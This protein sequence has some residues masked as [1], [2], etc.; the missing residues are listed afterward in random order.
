MVD[1]PMVAISN[2]VFLG[3]GRCS[4][5]HDGSRTGDRVA[6]VPIRVLE[7]DNSYVEFRQRG[8]TEHMQM[9]QIHRG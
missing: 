7:S 1:C 5:D 3:V 6:A 2:F 8:K 9:L 4:G